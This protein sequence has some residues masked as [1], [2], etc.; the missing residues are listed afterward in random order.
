MINSISCAVRSV[1][2][3]ESDV[4]ATEHVLFSQQNKNDPLQGHLY[5]RPLIAAHYTTLNDSAISDQ[6]ATER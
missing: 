4:I 1:H 3:W 5:K 6:R 2:V